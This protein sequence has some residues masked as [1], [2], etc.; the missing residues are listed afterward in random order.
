MIEV[1]SWL[2]SDP[3]SKPSARILRASLELFTSQGYFNTNVPDIGKKSNC[4]VGS[5]YHHFLNKEEIA[6]RLYR[7]GLYLFR[8]EL[9]LGLRSLRAEP[10]EKQVK[11]LVDDFLRFPERHPMLARYLWLC[12]HEEFLRGNLNSP[13]SVG[14]DDLGRQL[15]RLIRTGQRQ[16]LIPEI[17]PEIIWS[18]LFGISM[19]YIRDW[20][21][22]FA[23]EAPSTV[24]AQITSASWQAVSQA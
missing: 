7:D 18:L 12:R 13:T 24:S 19:S 3:E 22:G 9:A 14:F 5:I 16:G 8:S 20:L 23:K 4:S 21:E 1:P 2:G 11:R 17:K 10:V 6:L 15:T